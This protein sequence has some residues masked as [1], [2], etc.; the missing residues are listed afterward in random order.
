MEGEVRGKESHTNGDVVT[1]EGAV[2]GLVGT[3]TGHVHSAA[4]TNAGLLANLDIVHIT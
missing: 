2:A 4:V 1:N 3:L